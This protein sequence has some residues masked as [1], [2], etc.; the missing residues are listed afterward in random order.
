VLE[1]DF[2]AVKFLFFPQTTIM[3]RT[4]TAPR[5][6]GSLMCTRLT[7][8]RWRR[9]GL[10]DVSTHLL[11]PVIIIIEG[12]QLYRVYYYLAMNYLYI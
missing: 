3:I 2:R 6:Y 8:I 5:R 9:L 12:L 1:L 10:Q 4:M 7:L 11:I